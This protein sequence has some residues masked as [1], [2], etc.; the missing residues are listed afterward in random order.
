[1]GMIKPIDLDGRDYRPF[2]H[3]TKAQCEHHEKKKIK[4]SYTPLNNKDK[5]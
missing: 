5:N 4:K 3:V 1:M 2:T